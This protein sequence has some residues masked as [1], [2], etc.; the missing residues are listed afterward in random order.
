MENSV[1]EQLKKLRNKYHNGLVSVIVGAGFS[2]N[3]CEEYPL[4]QD[5]LYDMVVD[6]YKEEIA[7]SYLR[8]R[9]LN[10]NIKKSLGEF[11]KEEVPQII[12]RVGYLRMVSDYITRHGYRESIEH[13][14]E[15]RIPYIDIN[16]QQYKFAGKN[17]N[18]VIDIVS[19]N[20]VAHKKLLEGT[21]WER[22]YT[23]NYDRLLEYARDMAGM[24]F[25]VITKARDL[26]V[27]REKPSI[28][29]LH[30]DLY[31]PC[32]TD[33][34][35]F[36]FDGNPHQ[37]YIISEDDYK[38]YPT[39]HEAFTQLM[40]ISLLQGAF[41][42]IGFSGDDPNFIN[43]ISWVRDVLVTDDENS[44][45]KKNDY[46]IFLVGLTQDEP[47]EVR[48]IFYENHNIFFIPLLRNDV[49]VLI[50][51]NDSDT[52]R[53]LLCKFF[54]YLYR[55][56]L[57]NGG[58]LDI[59][60]ASSGKTY[61][62]LWNSVYKMN[63][64]GSMTN[65]WETII[66]IDEEKLEALY[67]IKSWNRFVN[68]AHAQKYF[69]GEIRLKD[70]ITV[71]EAKLI[72]LALRDTGLLADDKL[73]K[74]ISKS[75][76]GEEELCLL[77]QN[78]E[79]VITL[80]NSDFEEMASE[81]VGYEQILRSLIT[82]DFK[83]VKE[84]L[85]Q[86]YPNGI[87]L[88]K[89]SML[90]SLF[91]KDSAKEI[92]LNYIKSEPSD[93]EQ[94]FA[95]RLLNL[96][97]ETIPPVH[98]IDRFENANVQDYYKVFS[99][100][101]KQV[102]EN[103]EKIVCYGVGKKERIHYW[104]G[105]APTKQAEA[106]AVLNFLIE[107][108]AFVSYRNIYT[109]MSPEEWYHVHQYLYEVCPLADLYYSLQ[110]TDKKI[111]TRIGQDFAYSDSLNNGFI[112]DILKYLLKAFIADDT[113]LYLKESI[114]IV[115]RELFV[116]VKPDKWEGLFMK[117][118]EEIV[119][120][121][122]FVD[123]KDGYFEELDRFVD[124]ALNSIKTKE[125][126][127]RIICDVL[128]HVKDDTGFVINCLYYLHVLPSD[129]KG[130]D[131]LISVVNEFVYGI[132]TPTEMN[133][134]GNIYRLLND[135]QKA[136]CA[137]KCVVMLSD[138]SNIIPDLVYQVSQ[139]FVKEDPEKRLVFVTSICNNPLLWKNGIIGKN[140]FGDFKYLKLSGYSRRIYIDQLSLILIFEKLKASAKEIMAF[141]ESHSNLFFLSD[142][143]GLLSEM[144]TFLNNF[145][146]RL[147]KY[148]G[149]YEIRD[150]I[151][152]T[153]QEISGL[154]NTE[155]GLLSEYEADINKSLKY[156]DANR[157]TL[158]HPELMSYLDI[159]IKRVMLRNGDGLDLCISYLRYFL[160]LK[161]ITIEDIDILR[162]L[163]R[164]LDRYTKED[165]ENC[166]MDLVSAARDL[167]KIAEFLKEKGFNS[168]GI[169]YWNLFKKSSRFYSNF[170]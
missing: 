170:N 26:S 144:L 85:H 34:R 151:N 80:T 69:L 33:K 165:L 167:G 2:R 61:S 110:C 75:D 87:D 106:M 49:K 150:A 142:T 98:S 72:L 124:K 148:E 115:A 119:L 158:N 100:L 40:R 88:I 101:T 161:L 79:R 169:N 11:T 9:E 60:L 63:R 114:N 42:L 143:D 133:V 70:K 138:R 17:K 8:Y 116:S 47:D 81:D 129:M 113:P 20:F 78:V 131:A 66:T 14:I 111:K 77:K 125:T 90:L 157:E 13:Y 121:T 73:E 163:I 94:F 74:L 145:E 46:K 159:I 48:K 10:P 168:E 130:N 103:K 7:T 128:K 51:A 89:K 86:W 82:L 54:D 126:R 92:L 35:V 39:D 152:R 117:I 102:N 105:V 71:S 99:N 24:K 65:K 4:W 132:S 29:K 139:F 141:K 127:Q 44:N 108:P 15:E 58:S 28:I 83:R 136:V 31:Y 160:K 32:E 6:L 1:V 96:L 59:D 37:Q 123:I 67:S 45:K 41:C 84:L 5:L 25:N 19:E 30:G 22:I 156:I 137:E 104:N 76:I 120:K 164:I 43:W 134:A 27:S 112:D 21:K 64:S 50:E 18:K 155:D 16:S 52:Y 118:W 38:N 93:K 23:T 12:S 36:M 57:V 140:G 62:D 153:Y 95:T 166:N 107:A 162:G 146:E 55:K 97:E 53:D 122:R 3:A 147:S 68:N 154:K 109:L 56:E 91:E 135:E 149:Y